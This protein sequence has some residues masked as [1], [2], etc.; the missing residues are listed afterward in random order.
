MIDDHTFFE[1]VRNVSLCSRQNVISE[2]RE[3]SQY[4]T[5]EKNT[6]LSNH[7]WLRL[8]PRTFQES[9]TIN[10][11]F[12]SSKNCCHQNDNTVVLVKH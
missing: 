2:E 7:A 5:K 1:N 12:D 11:R 3:F 8:T 10:L 6:L 9:T 4:F